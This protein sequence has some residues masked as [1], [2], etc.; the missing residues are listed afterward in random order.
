VTL[1]ELLCAEVLL[2]IHFH[3]LAVSTCLTFTRD[4]CEVGLMFLHN[5][6]HMKPRYVSLSTNRE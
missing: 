3:L 2:R 4:T 1:N 5:V 6:E